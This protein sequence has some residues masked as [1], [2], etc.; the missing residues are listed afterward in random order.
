M[1]VGLPF[2]RDRRLQQHLRLPRQSRRVRRRLRRRGLLLCRLLR[3]GRLERTGMQQWRAPMCVGRSDGHVP[4]WNVLHGLGASPV[5]QIGPA[6]RSLLRERDL[7][8]RMSG[9]GDAPADARRRRPVLP[10]AGCSGGLCH[11][12]PSRDLR[13]PG[14]REAQLD[15]LEAKVLEHWCAFATASVVSTPR[16]RSAIRTSRTRGS[17]ATSLRSVRASS[18]SSRV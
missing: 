9:R 17:L 13:I 6:C 4:S 3:G 18:T 12:E 2:P 15:R 10:V 5:L 11:L 16:T 8:S 14:S 7:R 1:D